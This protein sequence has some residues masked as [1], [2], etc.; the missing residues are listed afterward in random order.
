M[1]EIRGLFETHLTVGDLDRSVAFYR[2]VLKLPLAQV[3]AQR[4]AAFFWIGTP[5]KAMLGL[6]GTGTSP[7]KMSLHLA[8]E[9]SIDAFS[10]VHKHSEKR[11]CLRWISTVNPPASQWFSDG[12][13][14]PPCIF[15][16]PME[17]CW[18]FSQ[19]FL[20]SRGRRSEWSLG[21][22]GNAR[23]DR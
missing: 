20:N 15:A 14:P 21:A 19:C 9:V 18:S 10:Q 5:G 23:I 3:F 2:D 1:I 11:E 16:I 12:C 13:L 17:I 8:F 7:Q 4:N 22:N 6:W